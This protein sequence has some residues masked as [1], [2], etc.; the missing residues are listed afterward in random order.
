VPCSTPAC[1]PDPSTATK[2]SRHRTRSGFR[3][4]RHLELRTRVPKGR[5]AGTG[6]TRKRFRRP[7]AGRSPC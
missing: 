4:T 5:T 6:A 3:S 7:R 1:T 2:N